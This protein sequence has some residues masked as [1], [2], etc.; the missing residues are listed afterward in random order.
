MLRL[1]GQRK[2]QI[3]DYISRPKV[4]T[5]EESLLQYGFVNSVVNSRYIRSQN[6]VDKGKRIDIGDSMRR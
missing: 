4:A 6:Y 2:N 3:S 1:Q 5:W